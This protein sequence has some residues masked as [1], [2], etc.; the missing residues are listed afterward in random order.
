MQIPIKVII[1]IA[2]AVLALTSLSLFFFQSSGT[3]V[4]RTQAERIFNTKCAVYSQQDCPWSVTYSADFQEYLDACRVLYG[5]EREAF[6]CIYMLCP[7]C[8]ETSNLRCSGLCNICSGHEYASVER[9]T[10][11]SRFGAE[12]TGS[13]VDCVQA[14]G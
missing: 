13:G 8:K 5:P 12:C 14:C 1:V 7:R 11:C 2:I 10:C 4:T 3:S 9:Q 6:S